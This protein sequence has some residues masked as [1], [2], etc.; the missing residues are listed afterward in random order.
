[1]VP[2][3]YLGYMAYDVDDIFTMRALSINRSS[4]TISLRQN[5]QYMDEIIN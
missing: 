3:G 2:G 5:E 1:M 4:L